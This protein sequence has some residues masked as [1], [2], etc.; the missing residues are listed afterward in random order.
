MITAANATM[1]DPDVV[2]TSM[3]TLATRYTKTATE[4]QEMGEDA[5]GAAETTAKLREEML[6]LS[7]VDIV[8]SN[9]QFKDMYQVFDEL[10]D[11]YQSLD[12]MALSR[13]GELMAGTRQRSVFNAILQNWDIAEK[14]L[15]TATS[16]DT[17]GSATRELEN[18][19]KGIEASVEH[20]KASFQDMSQTVINSDFIK[21]IVDGGTAALDIFTNLV[22]TVGLLPTILGG[23]AITSFFKNFSNFANIAKTNDAIGALMGVTDASSIVRFG[24]Q[25]NV[26]KTLDSLDD[27]GDVITAIKRANVS[28]DIAKAAVSSSKWAGR[29]AEIADA[30]ADTTMAASGFTQL[31]RRI[32][33]T[34]KNVGQSVKGIGQ[35]LLGFATA[36]PILAGAGIAATVAIGAYE[37]KKYRDTKLVEQANEANAAW[38]KTGAT[39]EQQVDKVIQL[40]QAIDSGDLTDEQ[41]LENKRQILD[42]Q[43]QIAEAYNGQADGIDL[44][45]GKLETQLEI[46]NRARTALAEE[47]I[48]ANYNA[49]EKS[50]ENMTKDIRYPLAFDANKAVADMV[51]GLGIEGFSVNDNG[52]STYSITFKGD[53]TSA[54]QA[55]NAYMNG[56]RSLGDEAAN[57]DSYLA[58][59]SEQLEET[60]ELQAKNADAANGYR[61]RVLESRGGGKIYDEYKDSVENLNDAYMSMDPQKVEEATTA[62]NNLNQ[63]IGKYIA[64]DVANKAMGKDYYGLAELFN[65][66]EFQIDESLKRS[67]DVNQLFTEL[68]KGSDQATESLAKT[69]N[70][71]ADD[72]RSVEGFVDAI[73]KA[74]LSEG[75]IRDILEFSKPG[76]DASSSTNA[77]FGLADALGQIDENGVVADNGIDMIV[78][79]L[80]LLQAVAQGTAA[81]VEEVDTSFED[82]AT[83][84]TN[85]FTQMDTIN[86]SLAKSFAGGGLS[87]AFDKETGKL[88][89]DV[90]DLMA[91]FENLSKHGLEGYDPE[92]LF[93]RTATGVKVNTEALRALQAQQENLTR[94]DFARQQAELQKQLAEA[95][96]SGN[97]AQIDSINNQLEMLK[98]MESAYD[99]ATSAY[100]KWLNAQAGGEAGDIYDNI[101]STALS[102]GDELLKEG[103]VGTNEFRAIAQLVSGQDLSTASISEVIDAYGRLDE[104]IG[105]TGYTIRDFFAEGEEGSNNF[106]QAVDALDKGYV[107]LGE[108]GSVAFNNINL[109]QLADELGTSVDVVEA[110]LNKIKDRGG[111][112]TYLNSEQESQLDEL[113]SKVDSARQALEQQKEAAK[114]AG[115]MTETL[116]NAMEASDFDLGSLNTVDELQAKASEL[117]GAIEEVSNSTID[118]EVRD[119]M[120]QQL[121]NELDA[122]NDK[123]ETINGASTSAPLQI[124]DVQ[125][126]YSTLDQLQSKLAQ[127]NAYNATASVKVNVQDDAEIQ[128]L[129]SQIAALDEDVQ[130]SIGINPENVGN[131]DAIVEQ[132]SAEP[133]QIPVEFQTPG[134]VDTGSTE[135]VDVTVNYKGGEPPEVPDATA[136]V[137]YELGTTPQEI[138]DAQGTANYDLGDSPESV[139]DASGVANFTLG[140]HPTT[141][142]TIT[143]TAN[144]TLGSVPTMLP[145]ATQFVLRIP[146]GGKAD[147]TMT[148]ITRAHADGTLRNVV[149]LSPALVNGKVA[150]DEDEIALVNE[151]GRESLINVFVTLHSDVYRKSI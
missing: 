40:R 64:Q 145:P 118:P 83:R 88:T 36:N 51:K 4:L 15:A 123:I 136:T 46:L 146:I 140:S 44:V 11:V 112:I 28:E 33:G 108:D 141:A 17:T 23:G 131:V 59:A 134:S 119:E 54:E 26:V 113:N 130:I 86:A 124:A 53:V 115:Q 21:T 56:L 66:E 32:Q 84:A 41:V 133:I 16:A 76:L 147:G 31:G 35:S 148:S 71:F 128:S 73:R 138:P 121:N 122:V 97:Q 58:M 129:A 65:T 29:S 8:D 72:T 95:T 20:F 82:F 27:V 43:G 105:T 48:N 22:D 6:A 74:D 12:S 39:I 150:L 132:I 67:F 52:D 70:Q 10:A 81:Q 107:T 60:S 2:G 114:Q 127:V 102:R 45:N 50:L 96:A 106:V 103:L 91:V 125:N 117:E 89:G 13:V 101:Q 55:I 94:L 142:P 14:T 151:V 24:A 9:G 137:N 149:N 18:W 78:S 110:S 3:K 144:Y 104:Q 34:F 92:Q 126:A 63:Q 93:L 61:K 111:E 37:Y 25:S 120:V 109:K 7:G 77:L 143:G 5:D 80:N 49:Y 85:A 87:A 79:G 57:A 100:Q 47:D 68:A 42:L 30:M 69:G 1:M 38:E 19:N 139:P 135:S 90:G 116:N 99:G 62:Y 75:E 98:L